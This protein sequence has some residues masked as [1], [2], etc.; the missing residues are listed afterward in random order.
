V[1][2]QGTGRHVVGIA[3]VG[4]VEDVEKLGTETQSQLLG[5]VKLPLQRNV[6]LYGTETTQHI[7]PKIT[8]LTKGRHA[9]LARDARSNPHHAWTR[10]MA[11]G[12]PAICSEAHRLSRSK[13]L[14]LLLL[15]S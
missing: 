2:E 10:R 6:R 7:T 15:L 1:A 14:N 8:L 4:V 9:P 3:E 12:R 13:E 5:Q 11:R